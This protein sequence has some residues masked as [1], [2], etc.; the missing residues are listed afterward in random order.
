[1]ASGYASWVRISGLNF[2][3]LLL[4]LLLG[5]KKTIASTI[6]VN[7]RVLTWKPQPQLSPPSGC[8]CYCGCCCCCGLCAAAA[9]RATPSVQVCREGERGQGALS[10][11]D[12]WDVQSTHCLTRKL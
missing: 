2:L 8:C 3:L 9:A 11:F 7:S 5:H 4:L 1:V 10:K 6:C 12:C